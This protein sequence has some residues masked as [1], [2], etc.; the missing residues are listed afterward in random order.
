MTNTKS[1]SQL[2]DIFIS[3]QIKLSRIMKRLKRALIIL[4][5][6][7]LSLTFLLSFTRALPF[8]YSI[9][10]STVTVASGDTLWEIAKRSIGQ[11]P[12]GI[13]SYIGEIRR[14]NGIEGSSGIIAGQSLTLP[15]Y[16]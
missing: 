9:S 8:F 15:V 10:E 14:L 16:K 4:V 13:R 12:Y 1:N 2:A 7:S 6:I 3:E 5:A 11:Y